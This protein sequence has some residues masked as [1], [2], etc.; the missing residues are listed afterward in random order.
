MARTV[1]V[2]GFVGLAGVMAAAGA[3]GS[4][5]RSVCRIEGPRAVCGE[6]HPGGRVSLR[7]PAARREYASP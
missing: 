1:F 5:D 7:P 4:E 6:V 2:I 3:T